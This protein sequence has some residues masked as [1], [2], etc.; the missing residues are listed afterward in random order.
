[1][2]QAS[3][4]Q[5]GLGTIPAN[6]TWRGRAILACAIVAFMVLGLCASTLDWREGLAMTLG[7]LAGMAAPLVVLSLIAWAVVALVSR[8]R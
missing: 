1:M 5:S 4:L 2:P 3:R 7:Q 6:P 8:R